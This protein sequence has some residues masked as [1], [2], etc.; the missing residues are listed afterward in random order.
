M[1]DLVAQD[2]DTTRASDADRD[3]VLQLLATATADGRL[4]VEEHSALMTQTLHARTLGELEVL[5]RDLRP[6]PGGDPATVVRPAAARKRLLSI[7]GA[8]SREG[9]WHV[10]AEL[11]AVAVFGAVELDFREASFD[12]TEVVLIAHS[13]FGAVEVTVP[14]WVRVEEEGHAIFG[15]RE[16]RGP[17]GAG[18]ASPPTVTLRIQGVTVFGAVEVRVKPAK[19]RGGGPQLDAGTAQT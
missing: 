19:R 9:G 16:V 18:P 12:T 1:S 13:W 11:T 3:R 17:K 15:A 5:T 10:P 4:T 2:G 8:R 7:F 14:E 6:V